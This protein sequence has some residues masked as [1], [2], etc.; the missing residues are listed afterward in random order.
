MTVS[1][2]HCTCLTGDKANSWWLQHHPQLLSM[3]FH[4]AGV[5]RGEISNAIDKYLTGTIGEDEDLM[6]WEALFIEFLELLMEAEKKEGVHK[7]SGWSV[8]SDAFFPFRDN[9]DRAKRSGVA[10]IVTPS[11]STTDKVVIEAC[12][13]VEIVLAHTDLQLFQPLTS[14]DIVS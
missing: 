6:K 3:K 2:T 1:D 14:A 5:K 13:K 12:D 4:K 7:L 8:S 10:C 9:V 11:G